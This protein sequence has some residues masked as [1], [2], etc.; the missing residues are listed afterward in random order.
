MRYPIFLFY[1]D[2]DLTV[3]DTPD[4]HW[5]SLEP[6][7]LEYIAVILDSDGR[8]LTPSHGKHR[9][10]ISDSGAPPDPERLRKMLI[11]VLHRKGQEWDSGAPLESLV[12]AAQEVYGYYEPGIPISEAIGNL[13]RRLR[14]RRPKS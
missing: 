1:D 9:A 3:F 7:D 8:L 11:H 12:P 2:N 10:E 4:E 5:D 6:D 14:L 13:L